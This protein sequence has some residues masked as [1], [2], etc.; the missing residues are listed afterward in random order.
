MYY[1]S[2]HITRTIV[3]ICQSSRCTAYR[4]TPFVQILTI[5]IIRSELFINFVVFPGKVLTF[6]GKYTNLIV[7]SV[8]ATIVTF[9]CLG[10]IFFI[11]LRQESHIKLKAKCHNFLV[12]VSQITRVPQVENLCYTV[13]LLLIRNNLK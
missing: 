9:V 4:C 11:S 1:T 8:R 13:Y 12:K 10:V 2:M 3:T 5:R 7:S 6:S